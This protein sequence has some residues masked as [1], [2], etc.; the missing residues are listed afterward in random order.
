MS[1]LLCLAVKYLPK[2]LFTQGSEIEVSISCVSQLYCM[3][4]VSTFFFFFKVYF[5]RK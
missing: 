1:P 4:A 2:V 3:C 5:L